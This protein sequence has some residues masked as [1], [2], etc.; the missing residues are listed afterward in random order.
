MNPKEVLMQ[1]G[2][3]KFIAMTGAKNFAHSSTENYMQFR[4]PTAN[5]INHIKITLNSKDL[6]DIDFGKQSGINYKVV[7]SVNDVYGDSLQEVFTEETGL[8]TRL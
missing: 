5:G 3:N 1:L 8:R 4:I 6:Y 2:G 7:K